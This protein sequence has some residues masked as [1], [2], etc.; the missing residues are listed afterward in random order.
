MKR[1]PIFSLLALFILSACS[2][3][4]YDQQVNGEEQSFVVT[5]YKSPT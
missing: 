4:E 3:N 2:A 1:F 5:V